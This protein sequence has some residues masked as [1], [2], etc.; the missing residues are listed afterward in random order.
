MVGVTEQQ[1]GVGLGIHHLRQHV[2]LVDLN[3]IARNEKALT[4]YECVGFRRYKGHV[5]MV[6]S[7]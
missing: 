6:K 2:P 1:P 7:L 4:L 3:V 5:N